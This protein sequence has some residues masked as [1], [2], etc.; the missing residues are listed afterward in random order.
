MSRDHLD[1]LPLIVLLGPDTPKARVSHIETEP[2]NRI[3]LAIDDRGR[4][5]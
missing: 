1:H 3:T 4:Q 5:T 2:S